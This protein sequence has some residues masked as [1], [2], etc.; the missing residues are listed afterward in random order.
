M[1]KAFLSHS[2][3][4]KDFVKK[5]ADDLGSA[6]A[7]YDERTFEPS[8]DSAEEILK[9]LANSDVFVLFLS[10]NSLASNWVKSEIKY[11]QHLYFEGKISNIAIFPLDDTPRDSL[12][13]WLRPLVVQTLRVPHLVAL[14]LRSL[15]APSELPD[16]SRF[17]G[18]DDVLK[19][20]K[21]IL[22]DH[23]PNRPSS[24]LLSGV[25]GIGRR[26]LIH[27]AFQDL[28]PFLPKHWV[29]IDMGSYEGEA[30]LYE[31]LLDC[32]EPLSNW[33]ASR[34]KVEAFVRAPESERTAELSRIL[35]GVEAT[36]QVIVVQFADDI[37]NAEGDLESWLLAA[38]RAVKSS[39]PILVVTTVRGLGPK[40]LAAMQDI[41]TLRLYSLEEK[42]ARQL[43]AFLCEDLQIEVSVTLLD[44][45]V[46]LVGG[47]PGLLE[48]SAKLIKAVGPTRFK[49]DLSFRDSKSA[50]EEYVEKAIANMP[51]S[52]IERA[53]LL[54]VEEL[55]GA[56]R[57]DILVG[58]SPGDPNIDFSFA[59]AKLLDFGFLEESGELLRSAPH[60]RLVMRRW[61]SD[62]K[63]QMLLVPVRKHLVAIL[64][65]AQSL[66]GGSYLALRG[67]IAAAIRADG[68]FN[69]VLVSRPLLAAQQLRVARRLYD[70]GSFLEAVE[71]ALKAYENRIALTDDGAIEVLRILG[72]IGVRKKRQDLKELSFLELD[73]NPDVKAKKIVAFIRGFEQRLSGNF[74]EAESLLKLAMNAGGSGDFHVLR[75]LAA[76]LLEQGRPQE[77]E[78]FARRA[79]G[80]A[81]TNPYVLDIM[82]ACLVDRLRDEPGD[83]PLEKEIELFLAR[84]ISADEREQKS[85][86][87]RREI[88]FAIAKLDYVLAQQLLKR[89]ERHS[90]RLWYK[91]VLSEYL[92][93]KGDSRGAAGQL[94]GLYRPPEQ[95]EQDETVMEFGIIR[96][97]RIVALA[98]SG[99]F[100][101][102]VTEYERNSRFLG[103]K[104]CKNLRRSIIEAIARSPVTKSEAV[105]KFASS[106]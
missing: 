101:E 14:R 77:A 47:H 102:A 99:R 79:L 96:R 67:P 40:A 29:A 55:G 21:D 56:T 80:I 66:S 92:L 95:V 51:L 57:E 90:A 32:F 23:S 9:A 45:V 11:A 37:V 36:K 52:E 19:Q 41:P 81:P 53:I 73:R 1:T 65:E 82:V 10:H 106:A 94:D 38:I 85:F 105:R 25:S 68:A 7:H 26:R 72:L 89:E 54:L 39:Y 103:A 75:E 15:L 46:T 28:Y 8:G 31:R 16:F 69:S 42:N 13:D 61:K 84:L 49:I 30:V 60:L 48:L 6:L 100:D 86:S 17:I 74:K 18:R 58:F 83:R 104:H 71:R 4:D 3:K 62:R 22:R 5:V 91:S 93:R 12:P 33:S 24:V 78:Q 76:S 87:P 98:E 27:R 20:L 35:R 43:L 70:E 59:L 44:Q 34:V 63:L 97:T 64:T 88:A 50:L 2:G